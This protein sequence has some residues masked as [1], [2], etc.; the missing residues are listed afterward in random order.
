MVGKLDPFGDEAS[1]V[2]QIGL[3]K[4]FSLLA[5]E[6]HL[7]KNTLLSG[8]D[9]LLKANFFQGKDGYFYSAFFHIS[10]G[11]ERILK[12]AVITHYMLSNHYQTPTIKQ[13]KKDFGHDIK[14][15]YGECQNLTV[16]YLHRPTL[17]TASTNS[18]DALIDFFTDYNIG[19]RYFNLNEVCEAKMER[20]P[21]DKWLAIAE[22]I[23]E[24]Y[25]PHPARQR[26]ALNLVHEMD[27]DGRQNQ[28]T[29]DLNE[30]GQLMTVFDCLHRQ[31][32]IGKSAP[33]IIWR[34][35]ESLRPV[36]FLLEGMAHK[37]TEYEV[38]NSIPAMVIPHYEDFFHFLLAD[39]VI[40]KRRK[41]WLEIFGS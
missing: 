15:L 4:R 33:L 30:E 17:I 40:I 16:L 2:N 18:D 6:A 26:S 24:E 5:Q 22:S 23:Y 41:K 37:A 36:H 13:L 7:A 28:F 29:M 32:V 8:F 10:I 39:K 20:S 27:R 35:I 9:L 12:L 25:T 1:T 14:T 3:D 11:M 19:S 31:Y 34:I 21:L 38:T